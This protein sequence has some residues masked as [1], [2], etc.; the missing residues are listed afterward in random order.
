MTERRSRREERKEETR[1]ELIAAAAAAFAQDVQLERIR[2]ALRTFSSN[3]F[4]T[5]AA[6]T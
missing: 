3:F 6:S 1:R 2:H 4:Q 5:P